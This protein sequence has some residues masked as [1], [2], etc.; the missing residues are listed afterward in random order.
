MFCLNADTYVK[1]CLSLNSLEILALGLRVQLNPKYWKDADPK[2][3]L[4]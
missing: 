1:I 2:L 3:E 4:G